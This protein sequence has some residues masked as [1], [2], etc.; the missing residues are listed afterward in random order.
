MRKEKTLLLDQ[1]KGHLDYSDAFVVLSYQNLDANSEAQLRSEIGK[2]GGRL[3]TLK[4]SMLV[5]AAELSGVQVDPSQLNGHISVLST[6]ENVI[7]AI[8]ALYKFK[9]EK[10]DTLNVL[11]GRYEGALCTPNDIEQISKLPSKDEMRSQFLGVL[12]AVP[13]SLLGVMDS[14]LTSVVHCLE[15]KMNQE[16]AS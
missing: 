6:G 1:I 14:L 15:N 3:M 7:D 13:A 9:E 16:E 8:K 5:K 4:K 2:T 12:E 10:E 11:V